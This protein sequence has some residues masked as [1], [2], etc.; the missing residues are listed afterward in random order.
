MNSGSDGF[1]W[2]RLD[3]APTRE[4][5]DIRRAYARV[6]KTIDAA[7][8]PAAFQALR[9]AYEAALAQAAGGG[10]EA[11][12]PPLEPTPAKPPAGPSSPALPSPGLQGIIGEFAALGRKEKIAAAMA[13]VDRVTQPS[14]ISLEAAAQLEAALFSAAMDDPEM[15]P[16]LLAALARRFHWGEVGSALEQRRPDL[17]NRYLHRMGLAQAWLGQ[18][19]A[20]AERP[21]LA[22]ETARKLLMPYTTKRRWVLGIGR[23]DMGV[24]DDLMRD[25][26]RFAPLLGDTFDPRMLAWL[27]QVV[28]SVDRGFA[29]VRL[30]RALLVVVG[31]L[32][33]VIGLSAAQYLTVVSSQSVDA[34]GSLSAAQGRWVCFHANPGDKA[35][36]AYVSMLMSYR[37]AIAEIRYGVDREAPDRVFAF[38]ADDN[39]RIS[40]ISPEVPVYVDVPRTTRFVTVQLR[41]KDGTVSPIGRY[42][43]P[44]DPSQYY[45]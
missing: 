22:G 13:V 37:G 39:P 17:Y 24:L 12:A 4:A 35:I 15:P 33:V 43:V 30:R 6:L 8:D 36:T 11:P 21:N 23:F 19:K 40:P 27:R 31:F 28:L 38:P 45:C 5:G 32:L 2:D 25:A 34:K 14:A 10:G 16:A 41:F 29:G 42:D 1:P 20:L 7:A 3:I 44:P 18:L 26:R 9:Q